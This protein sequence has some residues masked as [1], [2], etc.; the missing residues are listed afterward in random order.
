MRYLRYFIP[1][2][3]LLTACVPMRFENAG[4]QNKFEDDKFDCEVALGYRG[5]ARHSDT[6]KQL[7]E[8]LVNGRDDM[9][10]C[11]VRKGWKLAQN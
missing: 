11:L 8:I 6:S 5:Q 9:Q 10:A 2:F 3:I 1:L 4:S 7:A